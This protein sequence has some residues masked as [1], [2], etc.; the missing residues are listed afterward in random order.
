MEFSVTQVDAI[1]QGVLR[2]LQSRGIDVESARGDRV[3]QTLN[4]KVVTEA[5][6]EAANTA[7]RTV[8]LLAGAIITPSGYDYIRRNGVVLS[9]AV[10]T[11][12]EKGIGILIAVGEART[13][14][15]AAS[16]LCWSVVDADCEVEAA[17]NAV[18]SANSKPVVCCG[19]EPSIAACL[20]N[21][22][23]KLRAAVVTVDTNM[24]LLHRTM[25]PHVVCMDPIGWSF[26]GLRNL[27]RRM[28][29]RTVD[30]P[31]GWKELTGVQR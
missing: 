27:L 3:S 4:E 17:E 5:V 2:E 8:S 29:A 13:A 15:A 28:S 30:V 16:A 18:L 24:D 11:V 1:T 10:Q 26:T 9:S 20:I 14:T 22:D 7:G 6:L 25:N 12:T 19:G 21:R 31:A 23:R